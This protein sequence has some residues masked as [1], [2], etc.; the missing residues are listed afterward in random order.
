V[1][2]FGFEYDPNT[3]TPPSPHLDLYWFS[4]KWTEHLYELTTISKN[5]FFEF[6]DTKLTERSG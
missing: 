3:Q 5:N 1:Q 2:A 4:V 6:V